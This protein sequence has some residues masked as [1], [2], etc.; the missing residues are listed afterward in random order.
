MLYIIHHHKADQ[1]PSLV[2]EG[3]KDAICFRFDVS[4][5]E[6]I[7]IAKTVAR[8]RLV[9]YGLFTET[10]TISE[11]GREAVFTLPNEEQNDYRTNQKTSY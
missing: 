11:R 2:G 10:L 4:L 9:H 1:L 6:M 7:A 3:A 5:D 8:H